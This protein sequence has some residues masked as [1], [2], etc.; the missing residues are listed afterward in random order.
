[1]N[2]DRIIKISNA[3]GI[4]SIILLIYWVFIF[5]SI[6]V[7]GLKIFKENITESFYF[8]IIAILSLMFGALMINIMLN[9]TKISEYV[10][11]KNPVS[12]FKNSKL[13][14][15]LII[16][17]F[18]IIFVLLYWGDKLTSRQK[19]KYLI[20]SA[21]FLTEQ[22]PEKVN[23]LSTYSFTEEYIKQTEKNLE[24]LGKIDNNLPYAF[25]IAQDT[26]EGSLTYLRI[27]NFRM[28]YQTKK[29]EDKIEYIYSCS[30]EEKEYL[31]KVFNENYKKTRFSSYN[32]RY[33]LFYPILGNKK[34]IVIYFS[35]QHRYG[36]IGS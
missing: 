34:K 31:N 16:L 15:V 28:N 18:P 11:R 36:K 12:K 7:F 13:S 1:M 29:N 23:Q 21:T 17:S 22:Y 6:T 27:R 8:S 32:G 2:K 4:V 5:I 26:V 19:E 25:V 33:E 30:K 35:E 20:E 9:L 3:I 24:Y 14:T 10:D